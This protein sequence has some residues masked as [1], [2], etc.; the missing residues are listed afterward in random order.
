VRRDCVTSKST[1]LQQLQQQQQT[2]SAGSSSVNI[3]GE[4]AAV[5][6]VRTALEAVSMQRQRTHRKRTACV[7]SYATILLALRAMRVLRFWLETTR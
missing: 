3:S 4:T 6:T 2:M 1:S 5:R 7:K